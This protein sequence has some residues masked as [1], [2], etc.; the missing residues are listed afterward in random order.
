LNESLSVFSVATFSFSKN[1]YSDISEI[2]LDLG[3]A[4]SETVLLEVTHVAIGRE[5]EVVSVLNLDNV[6]QQV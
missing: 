2:G 6:G 5:L 4:D 3:E 1:T